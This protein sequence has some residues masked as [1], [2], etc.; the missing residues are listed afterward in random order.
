VCGVQS[1]ADRRGA[2]RPAAD[3]RGAGV[4]PRGERELL[5]APRLHAALLRVARL[6]GGVRLGLQARPLPRG[7]DDYSETRVVCNRP[8]GSFIVWG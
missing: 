6:R 4:R 1:H 5:L 2:P 8:H 3:V 7:E